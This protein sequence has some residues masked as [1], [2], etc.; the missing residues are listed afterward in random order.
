[1][2]TTLKRWDL[3]NFLNSA[4]D[5]IAYLEVILEDGD[6][7]EL[8]AALGDVARSHGM[9]E[10]AK[11]TGMSRE[12]LYKALSAKGNPSFSTVMRVL[13][14]M[15][16]RLTVK[17]IEAANDGRENDNYAEARLGA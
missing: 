7:A 1:M 2:P 16:L 4:D 10:I 3:A 14:A 11:I 8:Y 15:G 6:M 17:P 13:G 12:S 5:V 9:T